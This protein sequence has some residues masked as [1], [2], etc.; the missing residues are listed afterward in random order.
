MLN[1]YKPK[2]AIISDIKRLTADTKHFNLRF[3]KATDR[4]NF[5][6]DFGQFIML[7]LFGYGEIP[8]G[9]ASSP[10]QKENFEI[11]VRKAGTVT[12]GLMKARLGDRIGIRGP[13]GRGININDLKY[14][15]IALIS[16]GVGL[17]PLRSI[18]RYISWHRK[19]FGRT[20]LIYGAKNKFELLYTEEYTAWEKSIDIY[21]T[22]DEDIGNWT[23]HVGLVTEICNTDTLKCEEAVAVVC[24]PPVM[25]KP[26]IE[27]LKEIGFNDRDIYLL[28]ERQ[29][30][31]GVGK[32][33]HCV[34]DG[35]Y[36]CQDGPVFNYEE[37]RE[38]KGLI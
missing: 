1:I 7:S 38:I 5:R 15:N 29:M 24:G 31:C 8:L 25:Y 21:P 14:K 20:S 27:K 10:E 4:A 18:I 6:F 30:K 28:L 9:I 26:V 33:Q 19:E 13:Y 23:G 36:I 17:A 37:V 35:K 32:C 3:S 16:G 34:C 12:N 22:V 2:E 11:A